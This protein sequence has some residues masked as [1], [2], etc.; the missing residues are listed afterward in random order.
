VGTNRC[1]REILSSNRALRSLLKQPRPAGAPNPGGSPPL[2]GGRGAKRRHHRIAIPRATAS[3]RDVRP[4]A[5][6]SACQS[7]HYDTCS[8]PRFVPRRLRPL[9]GS[10]SCPPLTG[11][12]AP[13][14]RHPRLMARIP[15]GWNQPPREGRGGGACWHRRI[16]ACAC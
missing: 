16:G 4:G 11:G 6:P 7:L 10:E 14:S 5:M 15:P 8:R 3:R 1:V 12:G 2:A 9:P 13:W